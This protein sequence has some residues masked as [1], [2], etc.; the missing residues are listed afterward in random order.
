MVFM[1]SDK[2]PEENRFDAF[3]TKHGGYSNASTDCELVWQSCVCVCVCVLYLRVQVSNYC[4][5]GYFPKVQ[6]FSEFHE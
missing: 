5:A 1:G 6:I 2:Y 4:I 3:I